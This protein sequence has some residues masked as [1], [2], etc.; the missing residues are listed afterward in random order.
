MSTV[1]PSCSSGP[2]TDGNAAVRDESSV[3]NDHLN[4]TKM[5]AILYDTDYQVEE[6]AGR[7]GMGEVYK[8]W[9]RR[10]SR[11]EA[12]K[13]L[14]VRVRHDSA[15][16]EARFQDEIETLAKLEHPGLTNVFHSGDT[17]E[18]G[19]PWYTMT[20]LDGESLQQR[21]ENGRPPGPA[22][23]VEITRQILLALEY[24]HGKKILHRDLKPANIM[25]CTAGPVKLVDFGIACVMTPEDSRLT[26]TGQF[27]GSPR[28]CSPER[29]LG[30]SDIGA[31]SDLFELGKV[32]EEMVAALTNQGI[33]DEPFRGCN[34]LVEMLTKHEPA[35]RPQSARAVLQLLEPDGAD[36]EWRVDESPFPGLEAYQPRHAPVYFGREDAVREGM[37][38]LRSAPGGCAFL[39]IAGASGSGK[40]S[41]ARAG[42]AP[43]ASPNRE[44][45]IC[46]PDTLTPVRESLLP[47]LARLLAPRPD[48]VE[49]ITQALAGARQ[50]LAA[51]LKVPGGRAIADAVPCEQD[52]RSEFD[53][54]VVVD[55]FEWLYKK[56]LPAEARR[57]FMCG[58]ERLARTRG[59]AVVIALRSDALHH[60]DEEPLR[61]LASGRQLILRMPQPWELTRLLRCTSRAAGLSFEVDS[62]GKALDER[63][64]ADAS[65]SSQSLPLLSFVLRQ[66]WELRVRVS[67]QTG[68]PQATLTH[69]AYD[70]IG[71]LA[72][73]VANE[74]ER[75]H[76]DFLANNPEAT[77]ALDSLLFLLV[78]ADGTPDLRHCPAAD[79]EKAGREVMVLAEY[80]VESRLC[81]RDDA[82]VAF[83]HK[84]ILSSA[85]VERWPSLK[86]WLE[87]NEEALRLR[88]RI[89]N[90]AADWEEGLKKPED[91][92]PDG[93]LLTEAIQ[94]LSDRRP[95]FGALETEYLI[96]SGRSAR[97]RARVQAARRR[98]VVGVL[99]V[100]AAVSTGFAVLFRHQR[101]QAVIREKEA[102]A[103]RET[104]DELRKGADVLLRSSL[105]VLRRAIEGEDDPQSLEPL[106]IICQSINLYYDALP[107]GMR[108][109]VGFW[110]KGQ[111]LLLEA[112][113]ALRLMGSE[114][115]NGIYGTVLVGAPIWRCGVGK[116]AAVDETWEYYDYFQPNYN[117]DFRELL[118]PERPRPLSPEEPFLI[119]SM[120]SSAW[121]QIA[122]ETCRDGEAADHSHAA[123]SFARK[124]LEIKTDRSTQRCLCVALYRVSRRRYDPAAAQILKAAI[125]Q[126]TE[127]DRLT[128]SRSLPSNT[129]LAELQ[130]AE[131]RE[132]MREV[133]HPDPLDLDSLRQ[134]AW[135][136]LESGIVAHEIAL[137]DEGQSR[138]EAFRQ[139]R[140]FFLQARVVLETYLARDPGHVAVRR[141]LL[142]L[143]DAEAEILA[144]NEAPDTEG[145]LVLRRQAL[146]CARWLSTKAPD[147]EVAL[148]DLARSLGHVG[149]LLG[150]LGNRDDACRTLSEAVAVH[151]RL[152]ERQ[153]EALRLETISLR[154]MCEAH[155][156][157][158]D[159]KL[160]AERFAEAHASLMSAFDT[161]KRARE[162]SAATSNSLDVEAILIIRRIIECKLRLASVNPDEIKE[163]AKQAEALAKGLNS[164]NRNKDVITRNVESIRQALRGI[165]R[166]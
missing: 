75:A 150:R 121:V 84:T 66:L 7:G 65:A 21:L 100:A 147:D 76:T 29:R 35:H 77:A 130:L 55:Q 111:A 79:L 146:E 140:E 38:L 4:V 101:Q 52:R 42:I 10:V 89:S 154:E 81:V 80:F 78:S 107:E 165:E 1:D 160:R 110:I 151:Q 137:R 123:I 136:L 43:K 23:I 145:A 73:A 33:T 28:H 122:E 39:V 133:N 25:L 51:L 128:L 68:Q 47:G 143:L 104:S 108:D 113:V 12:L 63:L 164:D 155:L 37:R 16:F 139:A 91:L 153:A 57:A 46:T 24:I 19:F 148:R 69:E 129:D 86:S 59:V 17:E 49:P 99:V 162:M 2:L 41:L 83:A 61:S 14:R 74:A 138:V 53:L 114:V 64:V 90:R 48:L 50:D 142:T 15:D 9:N 98:V 159:E 93:S 45:V 30:S 156:R 34:Q 11:Y 13:V 96:D 125:P 36:V 44:P 72:G 115:S 119:A 26:Q 40:S 27:I 3:S 22:E 131:A 32:L 127:S 62:N 6:F 117:Y 56:S 8:V 149:I 87:K 5:A 134:Q 31:T 88:Q 71:R 141:D 116:P 152:I 112:Q 109:E 92:L 85:V 97:A 94:I 132:L 54:C 126:S 161:V 102:V 95:V 58:L 20:W 82:G 118:P 67:G 163:L 166:K 120:A 158:G 144:G 106:A 124:A 60:L 103:A 105:L 157:L 135:I 18:G 70:G